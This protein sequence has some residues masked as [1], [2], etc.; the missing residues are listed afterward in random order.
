I[1][2]VRKRAADYARGPPQGPGRTVRR[3]G[4]KHGHFPL[5]EF[6]RH[7]RQPIKPA[8]GPAKLEGD[9]LAVGETV[10]SQAPA[11]DFQQKGV[12]ARRP[13]AQEP[14]HRHWLLLR[15]R[16]ERP[17]RRAPE[18]R[19][20]LAAPD[21]SIT[22]SAVASSV[23]GISRASALAAFRLITNSYLVG[24]CTGRSLGFSPFR[25]RST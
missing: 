5:D 16:R 20:E 9:I 21:H 11:E 3:A 8:V 18:Q 4:E 1:P 23:A 2:P 22:A 14:D 10:F 7:R 17:C 12:R 15:A 13:P 25:M 6:G 19:D 24:A